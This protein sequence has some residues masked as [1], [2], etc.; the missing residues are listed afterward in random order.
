MIVAGKCRPEEGKIQEIVE[1][2]FEHTELYLK[3]DHLDSFDKTVAN[4]READIDISSV[5]TPHVLPEDEEHFKKTDRLAEKL[6]ATMVVHSQYLHHIH[7]DRVLEKYNFQSEYGYENNPGM[8]IPHLEKIILNPRHQMVLDTAHLYMSSGKDFQQNLE[9]FLNNH[10]NQI[11]LVHVCDSTMKNDGLAFGEGDM[12]M[13][14]TVKT[15]KEKF[16]GKVTLEVM[17]EHQEDA[18]QKWSSKF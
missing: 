1:K 14:R 7:I 15:I 3:T 4:C 18:L 11:P 9:Y 12:N 8:S 16:N 6:N 2:G 5:H 13:K 17:P 10:G